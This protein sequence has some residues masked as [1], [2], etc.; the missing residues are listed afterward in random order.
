MLVLLTLHEV[1][2]NIIYI[3]V[4]YGGVVVDNA[5]VGVHKFIC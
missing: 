3:S 5:V 2:S 1:I 4:V